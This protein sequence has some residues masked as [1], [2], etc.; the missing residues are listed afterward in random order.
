VRTREGWQRVSCIPPSPERTAVARAG[1]IPLNALV[2]FEPDRA[3]STMPFIEFSDIPAREVFPGASGRYFHSGQMT[4]GEVILEAGIVVP[5]HSHPH[6]Q[7]TVLLEGSLEFRLGSETRA[8][9]TGDMVLI[10]GGTEHG[11]R[12]LAKCRVLDVFAPA[13]LEYR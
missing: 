9:K 2:R 10:P 11:V 8:M 5:L 1:K 12:T 13:R 6:D 3:P 4:A 7:M